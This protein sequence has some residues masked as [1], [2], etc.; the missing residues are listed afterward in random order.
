MLNRGT[1]QLK[2]EGLLLAQRL[3]RRR[4]PSAGSAGSR[5]SPRSR[6]SGSPAQRGYNQ[7]VK[8]DRLTLATAFQRAGWR[9]VVEDPANKRTWPEGSSFYH[10]DK[11]YDRRNVG[12]RGPGFG[13]PP[14]P[15]QY[16][17]LALQRREL[18]KRHRPPLFAEVDLISSHAPWTQH[19][20]AD[21]LGRGRRRLDLRPHPAGGV[22]AG[23]ALR[24]RQAGPH[25]LRTFDRVLDAP[26]RLLRPALRRQGPRPRRPGR[27]S[28]RDARHRP[29][30]H[31]RRADLDH[32]PRSE[33]D[34]PDLR[35][36]L[37]GRPVAEPAGAGLADGPRS[38]TASSPRSARRRRVADVHSSRNLPESA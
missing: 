21:P 24:R 1:A 6:E 38:A 7:L 5:T 25:R 9:T 27:P 35:L 3:P 12:Y 17:F 37:A 19:P 33:G 20:P 10:Y 14:M 32:R 23:L 15:D 22:D 8:S 34:G 36:E 30:R 13:L 11:I 4:R 2:A 26:A 29:G 16:V 31:P 18:A 28:A